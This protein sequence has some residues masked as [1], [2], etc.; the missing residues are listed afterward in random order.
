MLRVSFR[1]L[2]AGGRALVIGFVF[3]QVELF[4]N[5]DGACF[6]YDD[7]ISKTKNV[8]SAD[9]RNVEDL[10]TDA[11]RGEINRWVLEAT[12]GKIPRLLD[13]NIEKNGV[14]L[15]N[16]LYFHSSWSSR[17]DEKKT[18]D[19]DFTTISGKKVK[20]RMMHHQREMLNYADYGEYEVLY[21]PLH[22]N[23]MEIV[24]PKEGKTPK[25][26]LPLLA[27]DR[28]PV[29]SGKYRVNVALPRFS[30]EYGASC[31]VEVMR[32][33]GINKA[34]DRKISEFENLTFERF[35]IDDIL[36]KSTLV[37]N[38]DGVTGSAATF[39]FGSSSLM[40]EGNEI[41]F[42]VDR[43]FIYFIR[44]PWSGTV[45]FNGVVNTL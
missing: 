41:D 26:I 43:P 34:F 22:G 24:L 21:L 20:A 35:Q 30:V 29:E 5:L 11:A 40:P 7:F 36:Q 23:T 45:L 39:V 27:E 14:C 4:P 8:F 28:Q 16:A 9:V 33:L 10:T 17:F 37:V 3:R 19:G 6:V 12:D 38:E 44:T 15:L 1:V 2:L 13:R 32:S 18:T 31:L 25:S 42:I